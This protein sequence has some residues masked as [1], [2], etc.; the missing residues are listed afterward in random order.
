VTPKQEL[1]PLPVP[2]HDT[3]TPT[4]VGTPTVFTKPGGTTDVKPIAMETVPKTSFDVD[5]YDP[6]ANDSYESISQEYYNDKRYA[7]ALKAHNGNRPLQGG[8]AVE[9][10]PIHILKKKFPGQV[11][12]VTPTGG[13]STPP[14]GTPLAGGPQWGPSANKLE[15]APIRATGTGRGNYIVPQGGMSMKAIARLTLGSEQRWKDIWDLNPPFTNPDD[16]LTAGTELRLPADA[17]IP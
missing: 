6:K 11:G 17:R 7:A 4:G 2:G 3:H 9:V 15:P 5:L 16:T 8:Q 10:P 14:T 13:T 12:T 1:K